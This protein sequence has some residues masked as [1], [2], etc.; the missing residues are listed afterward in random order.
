[1]GLKQ[2]KH[3]SET[4]VRV[5]YLYMYHLQ[6]RLRMR[7]VKGG[8]SRCSLVPILRP[9]A[10]SLSHGWPGNETK[11]DG[12]HWIEMSAILRFLFIRLNLAQES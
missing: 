4:L 10:L 3:C 6:P 5:L 8:G 9:P 7:K 12:A 11:G 2:L 1:M